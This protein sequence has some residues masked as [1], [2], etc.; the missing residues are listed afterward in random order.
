MS[1]STRVRGLKWLDHHQIVWWLLVALYTSAWIEML[2]VSEVTCSTFVALYTSAWIEIRKG[3]AIPTSPS[4]RTL[5]ECVDWNSLS[6]ILSVIS[7]LSHST[8]VRGLKYFY[9]SK[10]NRRRQVALY[11]SAWIEILYTSSALSMPSCRT[12]HECVDWNWHPM[13]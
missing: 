4:S 13:Y 10:N 11:T 6:R 1:H 12:L 8:R 2:I 5:H 9:T 3:R 7:L